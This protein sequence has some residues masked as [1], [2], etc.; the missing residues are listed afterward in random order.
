MSNQY[1][2]RIGIIVYKSSSSNNSPND[3]EIKY[4]DIARHLKFIEHVFS[5]KELHS[6]SALLEESIIKHNHARKKQE[7]QNWA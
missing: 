6:G 5:A 7:Y 1:E 4:V 3:N 2:S